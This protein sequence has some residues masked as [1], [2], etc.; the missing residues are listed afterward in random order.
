MALPVVALVAVL[1]AV[2]RIAA[3]VTVLR[4]AA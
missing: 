4:M 1:I 2:C 3:L